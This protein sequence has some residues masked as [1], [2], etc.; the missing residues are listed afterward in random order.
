MKNNEAKDNNTRISPMH[1]EIARWMKSVEFKSKVFGGVDEADV[2][3][4]IDE[5][6]LL[7]EKLLLEKQAQNSSAPV[8]SEEAGES[9]E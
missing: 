8:E 5:L 1:K 9:D 7:Y 4:K 3:K 2:W 6:N